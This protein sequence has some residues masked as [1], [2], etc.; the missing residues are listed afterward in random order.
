MP[1]VSQILSTLMDR[2]GLTDNELSDRVGVPQPTISRIRNGAIR[3]PRD[4]T[5]RPLAQYF[6][7]SVSQ[8]RG[9]MPLP[10]DRMKVAANEEVTEVSADALRLAM[11]IEAL[12]SEER[13]ALQTLVDALSQPKGCETRLHVGSR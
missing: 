3:D 11:A 1:T 5:L 6:G 10:A 12:T 4:S 8:L 7:L 13:G 2:A 9:D